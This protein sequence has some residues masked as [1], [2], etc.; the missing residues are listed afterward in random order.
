MPD[1]DDHVTDTVTVGDL[2]AHYEGG[3]F[4]AADP[5]KD[6]FICDGC[7][8][9][10]PYT[11][12]DRVSQY[13]VNNV[14]NDEHP[15][16]QQAIVRSGTRP[17]TPMATYCADC[18][19]RLLLLPCEGYTEVRLA[20]DMGDDRTYRNV[21]VTDFSPEKDGIP[22]NPAEL[23][24]QITGVPFHKNALLA[25]SLGADLWAPEDIVRVFQSIGPHL[26]IRSAIRADGSFNPRELD[27]A[28]EAYDEFAQKL[29]RNDFSRKWFRDHTRQ[30]N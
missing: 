1:V 2:E 17:F 20:F 13:I 24:E 30:D 27:R 23:S 4:T 28:R 8:T 5:S 3:D 16:W 14:I 10:V 25:A 21:E 7:T 9:G 29:Q 6:H 19:T 15:I 18:T 26:D 11:T 22:W 12:S